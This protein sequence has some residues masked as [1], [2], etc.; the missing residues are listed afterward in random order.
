M[1]FGFIAMI[2]NGMTDMCGTCWCL[3][4][5]GERGRFIIFEHDKEFDSDNFVKYM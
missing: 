2:C 1:I 4:G 3:K 5:K